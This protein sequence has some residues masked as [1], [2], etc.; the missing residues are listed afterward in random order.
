VSVNFK[1]RPFIMQCWFWNK[2]FDCLRQSYLYAL[3]LYVCDFSPAAYHSILRWNSI[4][5]LS[6]ERVRF[7]SL[8]SPC[9]IYQ[10]QSIIFIYRGV[11]LY[12]F[13]SKKIHFYYTLK[14][15][16]YFLTS[17]NSFYFIIR[18]LRYLLFKMFDKSSI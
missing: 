2:S 17:N 15:M 10:S 8:S 13:V 3:K 16:G 6:M 14:L 18:I 11:I 4:S 12:P 5:S 1:Q 7:Y 9:G